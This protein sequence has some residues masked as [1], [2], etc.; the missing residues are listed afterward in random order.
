MIKSNRLGGEV[1]KGEVSALRRFR[2][3]EGVPERRILGAAA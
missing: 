2:G 1:T 3:L